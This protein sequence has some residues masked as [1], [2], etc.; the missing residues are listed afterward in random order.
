MLCFCGAYACRSCAG[1]CLAGCR[2]TGCLGVRFLCAGCPLC[3]LSSCWLLLFPC[4]LLLY[5]LLLSPCCLSCCWLLLCWLSVLAIVV[6]FL[7]VSV[8]AVSVLAVSVFAVVLLAVVLLAV[9]ALAVAVLTVCAGCRCRL[10]GCFRADCACAGCHCRLAG[11]VCA[12]R[13]HRYASCLGVARLCACR[14][15][16]CC[17]GFVCAGDR[18]A[19]CARLCC[20][21]GVACLCACYRLTGRHAV[22]CRVAGF[23]EWDFALVVVLLA[24]LPLMAGLVLLSLELDI[25][26]L[27][28]L[29]WAS[30]SSAHLLAGYSRAG[31][32]ALASLNKNSVCL[33]ASYGTFS[34]CLE[35]SN[36]SL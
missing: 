16:P 24:V 13:R 30:S 35:V 7:V 32:V 34:A 17:W 10:S 27:P 9:A 18:V 19:G 23:F 26:V 21:V 31:L 4:W 3:C 1:Y 20:S 5:W 11:F 36:W 33:S 6:A 28:W 25:A 14:R 29:C 12:G 22:G 2:C 15:V 8:P